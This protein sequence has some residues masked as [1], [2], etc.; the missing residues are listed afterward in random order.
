TGACACCGLAAAAADGHVAVLYRAAAGNTQRDA[1]LLTTSDRKRWVGT[2]LQ[3]WP[4]NQCPMSTAALLPLDK[5]RWLTAWQTGPQVWWNEI[6]ANGKA[7]RAITAPGE[8]KG[9][10]HP[11]LAVQRDGRVL[12]AWSEGT[13]WNRGGLIHW[14]VF[15][16]KGKPL[17]DPGQA[18]GLSAWSL[19][20][21]A[22]W[23]DGFA[24]IY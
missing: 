22:S 4:L 1:I 2:D 18:D 5:N 8:A 6:A 3:P 19:P 16:G 24:L 11:A 9:R 15:D 17:G 20:A 21:V 10:K 23:G 7:G 12:F 13:G 14:Q